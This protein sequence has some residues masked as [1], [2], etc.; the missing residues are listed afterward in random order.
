M[1]ANRKSLNGRLVYLFTGELSAIL[2]FTFL[3]FSFSF[4]RE[5]SYSLFLAF[6]ILLFILLQ[7]SIYWFMKWQHLRT[8][9]PFP[10]YF[11]NLLRWL[12][13]INLLLLSLVPVTIFIELILEP[14][15]TFGIFV[16]MILIYGFAI[17]EYIN[18]FHIQLTN[19]KNGRW[20]KASIAKELSKVK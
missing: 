9:P 10:A 16:V 4:N 1:R 8:H 20:K 12:K 3:F 14:S 15:L 18:Y 2:V 7:A 5:E 6:F 17:I 19:Y 11:S 13:I